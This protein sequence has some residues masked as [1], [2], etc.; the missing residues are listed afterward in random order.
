LVEVCVISVYSND[1]KAPGVLF[2]S[3]S[4]SFSTYEL[5]YSIVCSTFIVGIVFCCC[6]ICYGNSF[7]CFGLFVANLYWFL[8]WLLFLIKL[9][10]ML[11]IYDLLYRVVCCY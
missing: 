1:K 6:C 4:A 9:Y 10:S 3:V 8:H 7:D 11:I 5:F 2:C